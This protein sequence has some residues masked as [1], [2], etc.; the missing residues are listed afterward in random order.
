MPLVQ[1]NII[2][3]DHPD[4]ESFVNWKVRE[5]LK[6]AAMVEGLRVLPQDQRAMAERLGLQLDYDFNGEAYYTVSGQN[7]NNSVR[8]TDAFFHAVEQDGS[9]KL[10][11][12]T[13]GAVIKTLEA[14]QLWEQICF[15]AWR[16][17]DPGIQYDTGTRALQ[18]DASTRATR[19]ASTCSSTT[20]RATSRR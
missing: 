6:V 5:E 19:A 7:S 15:A 3:A 18:P 14:K 10:T 20:R 4:I 11:A 8:L 9:W 13:D 16:C 12:R 17:A 1:C 2:D